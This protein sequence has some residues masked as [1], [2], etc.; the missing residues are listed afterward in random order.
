MK[1]LKILQYTL[2]TLILL[3]ITALAVMQ[4]KEV[5][6]FFFNQMA[7]LVEK[8]TGYSV[9]VDDIELMLPFEIK[10]TNLAIKKEG[11]GQFEAHRTIV[12]F[13]PASLTERKLLFHS[14]NFA[15]SKVTYNPKEK[16]EGKELFIDL[17]AL[18]F[19]LSIPQIHAKN[20]IIDCI[21]VC[22]LHNTPLSIDGSV[23]LDP[24]REKVTV[25]L[26][27]KDANDEEKYSAAKLSLT[28]KEQHLKGECHFEENKGGLL[29][30]PEELSL[31]TTID[32][33]GTTSTWENLLNGKADKS[34]RLLGN[35]S[36]ESLFGEQEGEMEGDLTLSS[37][38]G[39]ELYQLR[40]N[41][42]KVPFDG[43]LQI[44]KEE[45]LSAHVSLSV[46]TEKEKIAFE[47]AFKWCTNDFIQIQNLL[48]T[49]PEASLSGNLSYSLSERSAIGR[50]HGDIQ[51]L[52]VL[53]TFLPFNHQGNLSFDAYL[54]QNQ[55]KEQSLDVTLTSEGLSVNEFTLAS[56]T[57][58]VS[59]SDLYHHPEGFIECTVN[60]LAFNSVELDTL[61]LSSHMYEE[62]SNWPLKLTL[63]SPGLQAIAEGFWSY[64]QD[65]G[66][67]VTMEELSGYKEEHP[68]SL[69]TPLHLTKADRGYHLSPLALNVA[70]GSL[71]F[72]LNQNE[73]EYVQ[74]NLKLIKIPLSFF[75]SEIYSQ[76]FSG[77]ITANADVR[78][79]TKHL[80]GDIQANI[81]DLSFNHS[82]QFDQVPT[83]LSLQGKVTNQRAHLKGLLYGPKGTPIDVTA[84]LPLHLTPEAPVVH[85][86]YEAPIAIALSAEGS[87]TPVFEFFAAEDLIMSGEGKVAVNIG[88]T[89][90][91]P[92]VTGEAS[93]QHGTLESFVFGTLLHDITAEIIASG[94]RIIINSFNAYDQKSGLLN[95]EG[96]MT[97]S[98][99][100]GYPFSLQFKL[101]NL[102]LIRL[103]NLKA[104]FNGDIAISGNNK[105][106]AIEGAIESE[107]I[108]YNIAQKID[109]IT[110][111]VAVTYIN[112]NPQ[113]PSPTFIKKP[114]LTALP[115]SLN[116]SVVIP[117]NSLRVSDVDLS[118]SWGGEL[119]ITGEPDQL[120]LKGEIKL[121]K[122]GYK[123]NGQ[124][125]ELRNGVITLAGDPEK[126]TKL[127]VVASRDISDYRV[128]IVLQGKLTNPNIILRSTPSLPQQEIL[129]LILFG[130]SPT[131]I[132][133]TQ[134]KQLERSLS[135]LMKEQS[136]PGVLNKLQKTIGI[137]RIDITRQEIG[138]R[139]ETSISVGK[140]LTDDT[141]ISLKQ[142]LG[143]EP[144]RVSIETKVTKNLKLQVDAGEAE[145]ASS[146][147]TSGQVSLIWKHDY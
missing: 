124:Q 143:E 81:T 141:Y 69:T 61:Q 28:Q 90:N 67:S 95:G 25:G 60:N 31:K 34:E 4:I 83:N 127:Y 46:G 26:K 86:D 102:H 145:R 55:N 58:E 8:K 94:D 140:Y 110:E 63:K 85:F 40:G 121:E 16:S 116:L 15:D 45:C 9:T 30:L 70:K 10:A 64:Q 135:S 137:D 114:T 115:T 27:V 6:L 130:K 123:L 47:S 120:K 144:T 59:I 68:F 78:G 136:G 76:E 22:S 103:D 93:V 39:L 53:N 142:G 97:L 122:G 99:E 84:D 57:G 14:I 72:E 98:R 12:R 71:F 24:G 5:K 7:Q 106:V 38:Q 54:K 52:E 101:D 21:E 48:V 43:K 79:S 82:D 89:L 77:L 117:K 128:D 29:A 74:A 37:S 100:K 129:S 42:E 23:L 18:P 91:S 147:R 19:Y 113:E 107:K 96:E 75:S 32:L 88:G 35:F 17:S 65:E 41:F 134:D 112:Q 73:K 111:S 133:Y 3:I 104:I 109:E 80:V 44:I 108:D 36:L 51:K 131:E 139:E 87:L 105:E 1:I 138:D 125:F 2:L 132:S 66:L 50:L 62:V 92:L 118:S 20:L 13:N 11:E 33:V 119:Q 146:D 49:H 126:K 56:L